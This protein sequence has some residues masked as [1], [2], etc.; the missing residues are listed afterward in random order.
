MS[1]LIL[2]FA[3]SAAGILILIFNLKGRGKKFSTRPRTDSSYFQVMDLHFREYRPKP[4]QP[5]PFLAKR[6]DSLGIEP[7]A[8]DLPAAKHSGSLFPGSP[9]ARDS[10]SASLKIRDI[11]PDQ[12][13]NHKTLGL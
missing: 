7:I 11:E 10:S 5:S 9:I 1:D 3:L 12:E 4:N 13:N 8:E 6:K 2:G